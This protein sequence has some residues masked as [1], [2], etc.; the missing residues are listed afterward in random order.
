MRF[1]C[2]KDEAVL[3]RKLEHETLLIAELNQSLIFQEGS[4]QRTSIQ[5][6]ILRRIYS[7]QGTSIQ[8]YILCKIYSVQ[9]TSIQKYILDPGI[10]VSPVLFPS[11]I[12]IYR[13]DNI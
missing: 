8:K 6:Y 13:Q 11:F 3:K 4:V 7:V 2:R 12:A 5:K 9:R 1:L 10:G